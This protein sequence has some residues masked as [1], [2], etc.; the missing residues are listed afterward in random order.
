MARKLALIIGNSQYE[1]AGLARLAAPD[2]DVRALADVLHTPGIGAFDEVIPL[3]NEGLAT[4]R[5]AIARFFDAKHRDDLLLLY[6]SGHGV[7]DEQGHLYLAVRDTERAVLAGT[8]I[9]ASYV[10]TRMDRS[11]SK[12]LVL[13][14]DCCHSG[15]FGHGSKAAQCATVGTATAFEGTGRGRVVL[16]ATDSTQYAWEGDQVIGDVENSLFTH[17]LIEGLRTGA[18]DRDEDGQITIDEIYDYV[19]EHVLNETPKQTPGKWAFGQQGEIVI[20]QNPAVTVAKLPPEIEESLK[21]TLPSVRFQVLPELF[22]TV[23][24]RHEGRARAAREALQRLSEDDSRKVATGAIAYL[25]ALE[26]GEA[27][28]EDEWIRRVREKEEELSGRKTV[29]AQIESYLTGAEASL[30]RGALDE[31]RELLGRALKLDPHDETAGRLRDRLERADEERTRLEEAERRIRELRTGI[32]TL[33][34]RANATTV[35]PDAIALLKEALGLDP[36]HAEVR[37]LLESRHRVIAE[38]EAADRARRQEEADAAA[39]AQA[40]SER[41][42]Q[43]EGQ[44]SEASRH[45]ARENLTKA[46]VITESVLR[47]DPDNAAARTLHARAQGALE[48]KRLADKYAA[49]KRERQR[50]IDDMIATAEAAATHDTAIE[51]LNDVLARD[52]DNARALRLLSQ[53]QEEYS[54]ARAEL[55]RAEA[56]EIRRVRR[57]EQAREKAEAHEVEDRENAAAEVARGTSTGSEAAGGFSVHPTVVS[58]PWPWLRSATLRSDTFRAALLILLVGTVSWGVI[59]KLKRPV[60][61]GTASAP[62]SAPAGHAT[63]TPKPTVKGPDAAPPVAV[64]A[65]EKKEVAANVA[66]E[67]SKD[68]SGAP[69]PPRNATP[70][71]K[72]APPA[73]KAVRP[74]TTVPAGTSSTPTTIYPANP[75]PVDSAKPTVEDPPPPRR[76]PTE[77]T[78]GG[79][80]P[81][82]PDPSRGT[83]AAPAPKLVPDEASLRQAVQAYEKAITS[84]DRDAVR[85]VFPG[86]TE[87]NLREIDSLRSN[88]AQQYRLTVLIRDYRIDGIRARV[89]C[90]VIHNALDDRGKE[91]TKGRNETLTFEWTGRTWG[92]GRGGG[93]RPPPGWW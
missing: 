92:G 72:A 7:R 11:A 75:A 82:G 39:R 71:K 19:Y 76:E 6:F 78:S 61:S 56:E 66:P 93:G 55:R 65:A 90:R 52:P 32:S 12:R 86:I 23:R 3:L 88:F 2:V 67:T 22:G 37:Q 84:G 64:A 79:T 35:H 27:L 28:P 59:D 5:K 4:V 50:Q 69:V 24:G 1:D 44:L 10:T 57:E 68:T 89:E 70:D 29:S 18:A 9:E 85:R 58:Q 83:A 30:E 51:I 87:S 26:Q 53:R 13:V 73:P 63:E 17:Y 15:A 47:A 45:L 41:R 49:Q 74:P 81:T 54:A 21:S 36:E 33:I 91:Q 8:A 31:V 16:T 77:P 46:I 14:L 60:V 80:K 42:A 25:R 43:L 62:S 48:A 38:A 34:A 20:A 40:E